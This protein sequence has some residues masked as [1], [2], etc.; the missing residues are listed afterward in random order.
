MISIK[1]HIRILREGKEP[2]NLTEYRP[3]EGFQEMTF[4]TWEK[5]V[6]RMKELEALADDG[7]VRVSA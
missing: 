3:R 1:G 7:G 6:E 5:F 4:S 2:L